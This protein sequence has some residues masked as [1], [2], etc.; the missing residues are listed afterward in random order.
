MSWN[1]FLADD[2]CAALSQEGYAGREWRN[3]PPVVALATPSTF[4]P[5]TIQSSLMLC[6]RVWPRL[7]VVS[8]KAEV[9]LSLLHGTCGTVALDCGRNSGRRRARLFQEK[10]RSGIC[11]HLIS[12]C[13]KGGLSPSTR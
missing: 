5:R 6:A 10:F 11:R 2:A 8:R 7:A 4:N 3:G 13:A 9:N 12:L 1:S